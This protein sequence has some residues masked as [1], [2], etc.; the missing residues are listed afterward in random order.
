LWLLP[1]TTDIRT[2]V[3]S[4]DYT[5]REQARVVV[6]SMVVIMWATAV[7]TLGVSSGPHQKRK[8]TN[9]SALCRAS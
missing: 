7:E 6:S 3:G 5:D 2:L 8:N 9:D 4:P 1:G